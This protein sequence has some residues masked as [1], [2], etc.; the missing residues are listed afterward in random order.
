MEI[1]YSPQIGEKQVKFHAIIY[2][3]NQEKVILIPH[4][5]QVINSQNK[6]LESDLFL[7]EA[8]EQLETL[9]EA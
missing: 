4:N 3:I 2:P 8:D 5:I 7:T 9:L 6:L 1:Q